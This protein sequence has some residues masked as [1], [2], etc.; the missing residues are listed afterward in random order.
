MSASVTATFVFAD[1]AGF[2]ALTEA[3]GDEE[4][5]A[6]VRQFCRAVAD[7]LPAV[8]G[9][10]VKTIGDAVMLSVP[11]PGDA[12]RLGLRITHELMRG[13]GA[14]AVRVGLHHGTA[15]EQDGDYIG[16]AVNLAARVSA[17]ASAGEVLL[18]GTTAALAARIDGVV[19]EPR[20]RRELR[21][22]REPVELFAAVRVGESAEDRLPCDPVCRM[23]VDPEKAAGRLV[24]EDTAY[25][26]CTLAC[27]G[28]FARRPERFV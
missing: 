11:E 19:Y 15:V 9:S 7:E 28:E 24:Y 6:L 25:F 27:A 12:I 10:Q 26:F 20:G 13:H 18:T 14:P 16:A 3:H 17:E 23:A 2:T 5:A 8:R 22:V 1:I 4:A 21:N